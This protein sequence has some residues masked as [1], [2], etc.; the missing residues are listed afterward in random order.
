M[1]WHERFERTIPACLA[2]IMAVSTCYGQTA[3][4]V[5]QPAQ[6]PKGA[7]RLSDVSMRLFCK[8][9]DQAELTAAKAFHITRADWSYIKD[10]EYI[11]RIHHFGWTFQGTMNAVTHN[12]EHAKHDKNG[13]PMLDH[14]GKAGRYWADNDN[15]SYRQWYL[16]QLKAWSDAGA[17]SIQRDEPTTAQRTPIPDAARFFK[18]IHAK[19]DRQLGRHMPM[20]C[21]LSW[22]GSVFGG[23]GE[24]VT[25]L[26][27]FGMAEMSRDKVKPE[28]L[29]RVSRDA[30]RRGKAMVYTS[31]QNLGI[32]TYRLAIAGCYATGMH[33]LVPW[34]QFAGVNKPRVFSRPEELADLYG[35]VR[36]NARY[37]DG[38]EDV[39]ATGCRLKNS[40][41]G[42]TPALNIDAA[43]K[44][45]AFVRARPGD[46]TAPVVVHLIDWGK[47]PSPFVIKL[48]SRAFFAS[49]AV[50]ITLHIPVRYDARLHKKTEES[51]TY[52]LLSRDIVLPTTPQDDWIVVEIPAL[53]PWGILTVSRKP[54]PTEIEKP[55]TEHPSHSSTHTD[56]VNGGSTRKLKP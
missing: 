52:A 24:P 23:K 20:S 38:Y 6:R 21:N 19:F 40:Y 25:M 29:L 47:Q 48:R 7:P 12:V 13:K 35:F 17:D 55:L 36:A 50:A 37:L 51:Q 5:A 46:D 33:F 22:N 3:S 27:D 1:Y 2:G 26:F 34:D 11:K 4:Q 53:Q 32:P 56:R 39:A 10:P 14:F 18:D 28:F 42:K 15:K 9:K 8:K 44:V 30:C 49:G 16:N 41:C 45:S 31:H 43:P 54:K